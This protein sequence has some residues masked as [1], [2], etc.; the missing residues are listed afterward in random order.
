M[1]STGDRTDFLLGTGTL[2]VAAIVIAAAW[3]LPPALYDP[4]GPSGLPLAI[5]LVLAVLSVALIVQWFR[6]RGAAPDVPGEDT[7]SHWKAVASIGLMAAFVALIDLRL[8]GFR[9]AAF[10]LFLALSLIFRLQGWRGLL[11]TALCG[12]VLIYG[13]YW[14]FTEVL[15]VNLPG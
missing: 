11:V 1:K 5:S 14:L 3:Q 15:I 4:L 10:V 12:L 13:G 7:P 6:R 2:L 8:V 9:E